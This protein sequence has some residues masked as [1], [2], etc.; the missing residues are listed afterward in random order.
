LVILIVGLAKAFE[1]MSDAFYGMLQ[2]HERM[3]RIA[4]SMM[5]KGPL[6]LVA[7]GLGF[8]LTG[9]LLW[10]TI[11]MA[12]TWGLVL[13]GY[14][15]RSGVL[16]LEGAQRVRSGLWALKPRF[17]AATLWKLAYLALPLGLT[18]ALISLNVNI[19][20][21]LTEYY[22]DE[23]LLGIYAGISYVL[24]SGRLVSGALGQSSSP[25]LARYYAEGDYRAYSTLLL[26]LA[27]TGALIGIAGVLAALI[28]GRWIL[29]ILYTPEYAEYTDLFVWVMA[30]TAV[31]YVVAF[32][33]FGI[34]A[35]RYFRVQVPLLLGVVVITGLACLLLIPR[36]GILGAGIAAALGAVSQL[37]AST[38]VVLYL[39]KYRQDRTKA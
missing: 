33:N 27:T 28:A 37:V 6:S 14:D 29:T 30:A 23:R 21:Y 8:Y 13:V 22:L 12:V 1:A 39:V 32:L 25:R 19:P 10:G 17:R 20:R 2:Q 15:I 34:V 35:A 38:C 3:D 31:G 26:R 5:I 18:A 11:C 16:V 4:Q 24:V 7:L 9:S 36:V